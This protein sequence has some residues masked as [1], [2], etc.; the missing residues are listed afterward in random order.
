MGTHIFIDSCPY[1]KYIEHMKTTVELSDALLSELKQRAREQNSSMK[2]LMEAALRFY[3]DRRQ[4][5]KRAFEFRNHPFK[6]NGVCEGVEEGSW[7]QIRSTIY[8]GRGG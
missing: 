2:E 7:E 4:E 5:Q 3:L 1:L 6:G 8:E